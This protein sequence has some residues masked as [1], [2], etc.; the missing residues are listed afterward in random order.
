MNETANH[1]VTSVIR[2]WSRSSRPNVVNVI[3]FIITAVEENF[4]LDDSG[5]LKFAN[6]AL[7]SCTESKVSC[8][9]NFDKLKKNGTNNYG[10]TA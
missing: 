1:S 2:F 6:V 4:Q 8:T 10:F 7:R 9:N 5:I 3:F